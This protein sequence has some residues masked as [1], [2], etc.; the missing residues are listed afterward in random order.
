MPG[1]SGGLSSGDGPRTGKG[2]ALWTPKEDWVSPGTEGDTGAPGPDK[3]EITTWAVGEA[4]GETAHLK[5]GRP[6]SAPHDSL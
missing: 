2:G 3:E 6:C 1:A 5:R 4:R